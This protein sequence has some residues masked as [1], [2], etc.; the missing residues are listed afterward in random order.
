MARVKGTLHIT[1]T[2]ANYPEREG[3]LRTIG[4]LRYTAKQHAEPKPVFC[5]GECLKDY[6]MRELSLTVCINQDMV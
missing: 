6:R 4:R 1:E 3:C 2:C 5:S